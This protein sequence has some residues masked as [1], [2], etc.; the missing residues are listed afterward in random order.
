MD[1]R[2]PTI[3]IVGTLAATYLSAVTLLG[4][5]GISYTEGPLVIAATG[6]FG[7]WIGIMLAV[8]YVGRKLKGL[9]CRTMPDFFRN[10]FQSKAVTTLATLIMIIGL[11]GYGVIQLIGAGLVLEE[12][13]GISFPIIIV[14]FVIALMVFSALGGMYGVVVTDTLMFFTM[15]AVAAVIAPFIISKAGFADMKALGDSMPGYWSLAGAQGRAMSFTVSQ[16]LVWVIFMTCSPA[17]VSRVFPAK[18][19]FVI[20]KAAGIG[21]FLAAAMQIPIFLAASAMQVIEPGIEQADRVMLIAFIEH[22]PG[23]MGGIGLAALMAAIMSTASTLFVLAGF[24]LSHDLY[25]NLKKDS[26]S[27]RDKMRVSRIAQIVI[28]VVVAIIAIAQ[29]AGIYW[30]SIYAAAIFGVGWLPTVVAGLEWRRMNHKAALA[31]MIVGVSVF[32]LFTELT[33]LSYITLP[34]YA[35]PLIIAFSSAIVALIVVALVTTP[36][37]A[38]AEYFEK[39]RNASSSAKTIS[40]ILIKANGLQ[41][42][43]RQYRQVQWIMGVVVVLALS[44]FGLLAVK[45]AF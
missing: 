10:R 34:A 28:G 18:N 16:F 19:D 5:A 23:V 2:A 31:S 39:I 25:E 20:L 3:L 15:L 11:L 29:P 7:S 44:V 1:E 27:E 9:G 32:V 14:A 4:I 35:T 38:E 8:L 26:L 41:E 37:A 36:L 22:V 24:G 40:G 42:L 6:S 17:M 30:I 43:K 13:T 12:I 33:R 45:L 21:V